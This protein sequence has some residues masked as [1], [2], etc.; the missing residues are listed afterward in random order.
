MPQLIF[1]G[2]TESVTGSSYIIKT[3]KSQIL[4]ECGLIQG[5]FKEEKL[6]YQPFPFSAT[7]LDAAILSHAH[8][9]H[10]GRLPKLVADR[11]HAPIFMTFPTYDLLEI[12]L[13]DAAFIE[14][15]DTEWENKQRLRIGKEKR[16][17]LFTLD[18]VD[19]TL[20]NCRGLNYNNRVHITEDIEICLLDAGHILG[21][22]IIE[23]YIHEDSSIKKLVFS[24]DLGNGYAAILNDPKIVKTA[25]ILLMESTYG[26]RNHRPMDDT[27]IEL[28]DIIQNAS[29]NNGNILIPAFAVGRTQ[30]IIFR[31][32]ELYQGG[33]L[34]H[35]TVYLD[36]PMAIAATKV[37]HRHQ[38]IFSGE[39]KDILRRSN[40]ASLD[41]FLPILRYSRTTE[42]S[43]MLNNIN[44]GVIIIAGSGMCNGGRIRHHLKHNLY[45]KNAHIIIVGFQAIGTPGRALIDG[46]KTFRIG[47][48]QIPV[49]AT[50]HTL[51]GFSAHADQS[52]LINWTDN[53]TSPR[54]NIYLI[55]GEK[56]AKIALSNRLR[57]QKWN[58]HIPVTGEAINF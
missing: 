35:H 36:S 25:D 55:H 13:K 10:S 16:S 33:K 34:Q 6:N 43:M 3:K 51:G 44:N 53:F 45:K 42:E 8:L 58:V 37:Y 21:S 20:A 29:E 24:G 9:D 23:L 1:H 54:P 14:Q 31:L 46:A 38:D 32:G 5:T 50:I 56:N 18:D 19:A 40:A 17:P 48:E 26:D 41:T 49:R 47:D 57:E 28:E 39:D 11:C 7:N 22:A 4:I 15:R 12:M 52:Q 30:E 2:A 27:L